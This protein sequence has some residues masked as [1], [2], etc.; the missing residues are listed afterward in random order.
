MGA[1]TIED[2]DLITTG[3]MRQLDNRFKTILSPDSEETLSLERFKG[4]MK[5]SDLGEE[6]DKGVYYQI[7]M[8]INKT[9][10]HSIFYW[11]DEKRRFSELYPVLE[12]IFNL[13]KIQRSELSGRATATTFPIGDTDL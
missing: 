2:G 8:G 5:D 11:K 7:V 12:A 10:K 13:K 6:L 3:M 4:V 1:L 9:D